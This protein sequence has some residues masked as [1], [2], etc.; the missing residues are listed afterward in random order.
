MK[1]WVLLIISVTFLA[2]IKLVVAKPIDG[3]SFGVGGSES[4]SL[5]K[6]VYGVRVSLEKDWSR[7]FFP[8]SH[9]HWGGFWDLNFAHFRAAPDY[10]GR[11]RHI[12]ILALNPI[13]RL[14]ADEPFSN[15]ILPFLEGSVGLAWGNTR[16]CG[17]HDLGSYFNFEDILGIGAYF[18]SRQQYDASLRFIHYSNAGL[19]FPNA[20]IS[21]KCLATVSYHF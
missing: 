12:S 7:R 13:F 5:L 3:V 4:N 15:S 19:G 17:G 20:G 1:R 14:Q 6:S 21:I 2:G 11:Y 8:S 18:G 9:W 16:H 10:M